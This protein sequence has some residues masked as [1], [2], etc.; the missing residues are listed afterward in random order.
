[1]TRLH[2]R[3][4]LVVTPE[5]AVECDLIVVQGSDTTEIPRMLA[6]G[7]VGIKAFMCGSDPS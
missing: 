3:G 1:M 2:L 7:A 6:E 4:G 5:G